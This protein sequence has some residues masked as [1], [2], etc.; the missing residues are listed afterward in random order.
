MRSERTVLGLDSDESEPEMRPEPLLL[1][2]RLL[3]TWEP[4][5]PDELR[6]QADPELGGLERRAL[7]YTSHE[8][9]LS[10]ICIPWDTR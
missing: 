9:S 6:S 3:I 8:T 1:C 2:P 4:R 7:S 10:I 5:D